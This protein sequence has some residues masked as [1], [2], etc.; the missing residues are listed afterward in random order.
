MGFF[1]QGKINWNEKLIK[2]SFLVTM[3]FSV[4]YSVISYL[5]DF[6]VGIYMMGGATLFFSALYFMVFKI[7]AKEILAKLFIGCGAVAIFI[8]VCASGGMY[9]PI[10]P[11]VVLVPIMAT[12]LTEEK[13][14]TY[15]GLLTIFFT[16]LVLVYSENFMV[17]HY[18]VEYRHYFFGTTLVG[19][20]SIIFLIVR[21]FA[22]TKNE[23]VREIEVTNVEL[24]TQKQEIDDSI[25]YAERIQ[26]SLLPNEVAL[27]KLFPNSFVMFRP[28][29]VVSGDFYWF[30]KLGKHKIIVAADCTGHGVPGAFMSILGLE[31]LDNIIH[32]IGATD[33]AEILNRMNQRI[34]KSLRQEMTNNNDSMDMTIVVVDE[35]NGKL[36]FAGA[37]N[38]LIYKCDEKFT[39]IKGDRFSV[40]GY[41]DGY[42]KVFTSHEVDICDDF[43][44]YLHSDGFKDQFGGEKGKKYKNS[45]FKALL[46]KIS[47][48]DANVQLEYANKEFEE[49]SGD[50]EQVDDVLLIGVKIE[51]L[52]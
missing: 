35:V 48:Y 52:G 6:T 28:K 40:G 31:T 41:S 20:I 21:L 47:K 27:K 24:S 39:V 51:K 11:W 42:N 23:L 25:N 38:P 9:S 44:L 3:G 19:L 15:W 16:A 45:R 33:P 4:S 8:L 1:N 26:K 7:G 5:V 36:K 12:I 32:N 13:T 30:K 2:Q 43:T 50:Y 49:W 10:L 29:D 37:K 17:P 34:R 46:E 14:A 18:N 22:N